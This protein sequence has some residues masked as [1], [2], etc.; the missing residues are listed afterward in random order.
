MT[1][2]ECWAI[3]TATTFRMKILQKYKNSVA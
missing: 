1:R 3:T 2:E